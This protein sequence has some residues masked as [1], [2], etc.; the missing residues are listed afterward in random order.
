M[1]GGRTKCDNKA[2]VDNLELRMYEL[3]IGTGNKGTASGMDNIPDLRSEQSER[4]GFH[5]RQTAAITATQYIFGSRCHEI[6]VFLSAKEKLF[7]YMYFFVLYVLLS[8][9]LAL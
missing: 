4:I 9:C 2:N 7:I 3:E 5:R 1:S 6:R 8:R